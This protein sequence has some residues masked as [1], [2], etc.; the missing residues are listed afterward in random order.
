VTLVDTN[1]LIDVLSDDQGWGSWSAAAI[2]KQSQCGPVVI[3]EM[4]Y[5]ELSGRYASGQHLDGVVDGLQLQFEWLPKA[6]L[7]LAGHAFRN[8]RR[9]GGPRSSILADFF[10]GAHAATVQIPI[11]TR[12]ARRYQTYFPKVDLITPE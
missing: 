3:N 9:A 5:A 7:F 11:L 2:E 4:V 8:Y 10:I 1:V 6:A 12:D